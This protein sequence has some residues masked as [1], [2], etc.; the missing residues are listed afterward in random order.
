MAGYIKLHRDIMSWEWYKDIPVRIL[1]EHCLL[2]ANHEPKRWQGQ[3]VEAG[4]FITSRENLAFETGLTEMQVRIAIKKLN[5][6][7]EITSKTTNRYTMITIN[8][9]NLYQQNNQQINQQISNK[10]PTNNH[11]QE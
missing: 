11:K 8:N 2:K 9:W 4:Q 5:S 6:T 3:I 1:F 10:Y 7:S